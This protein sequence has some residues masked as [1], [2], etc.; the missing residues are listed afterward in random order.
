MDAEDNDDFA[1]LRPK[2][3]GPRNELLD[4]LRHIGNIVGVQGAMVIT[5]GGFILES[6]IDDQLKEL[7]AAAGLELYDSAE[8]FVSSDSIG[9]KRIHQAFGRTTLGWLHVA[10]FGGGLV[11]SLT[12]TDE[13]NC[14]IG[15]ATRVTRLVN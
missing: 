12:D 14:L 5:P 13:L 7:V 8:S 1:S 10:D 3:P 11:I 2:R 6:T 15:L 4:L 9:H